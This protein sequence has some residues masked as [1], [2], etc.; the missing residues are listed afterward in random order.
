MGA[1]NLDSVSL[2]EWSL[3]EEGRNKFVTWLNHSS[4]LANR[5]NMHILAAFDVVGI[6]GMFLKI[7]SGFGGERTSADLVIPQLLIQRSFKVLLVGGAPALSNLRLE[8]FETDFPLS[9]VCGCIDGFGNNVFEQVINVLQNEAPDLVIIGMG[10][11]K[12]DELAIRLKHALDPSLGLVIL[13]CGGWLD[14]LIT[15][16]YYPGWAYPLRLNW[17]VRLLRE[18]R[19]LWRRYTL[20]ALRILTEVKLIGKLRTLRNTSLSPES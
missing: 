6:D 19:R 15:D 12:Q 17:L 1:R 5:T 8:R 2:I 20:E 13:T 7:V 18:P 9:V 10:A 14:Q 16:N 4:L 3:K 11:P